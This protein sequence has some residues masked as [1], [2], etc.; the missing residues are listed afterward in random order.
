[1]TSYM[2]DIY[3]TSAS[4]CN[5]LMDKLCGRTSDGNGSTSNR[6]YPEISYFNQLLLLLSDPSV[7]LESDSPLDIKNLSEKDNKES[8]NENIKD[9]IVDNNEPTK[10][11]KEDNKEP[12][13]DN[14]EDNKDNKEP[15]NDNKE[16]TNDNKEPT[17]DNAK[18]N[19]EDNKEKKGKTIHLGSAYN[20]G[21]YKLLKSLDIK[22][23]INVTSD[24]S[25]YFPEEF[26]Y[27]KY[28]LLDGDKNEKTDIETENKQILNIFQN[29]S[30]NIKASKGNVFI[31]CFMGA[32][33]SVCGLLYYLMTEKNM[34]LDKGIELIKSKRGFINPNNR[35]ID[36]LRKLPI[37]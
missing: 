21:N 5:V 6:L 28:L 14:K 18:D 9:N 7:I 30:D 32:S 23:V 33:R 24:I 25:N 8:T 26:T 29:I 27:H 16:P 37:L 2:Y 20:A 13:T 10:D 11:N 17:N 15:T 12:T 1:M 35:F 3:N 31:H 19:K 36:V 4:L 34:T 22:T